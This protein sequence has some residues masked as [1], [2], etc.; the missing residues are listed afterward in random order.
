MITAATVHA[1]ARGLA[2]EDSLERERLD[3]LVQSRRRIERGTGGAIHDEF[4]G[5]EQ[6]A[7]PDVADMPVITKT[8][9]QPPLELSAKTLDPVEQLLVIDHP[10]YLER[11]GAGQRMGQIGMAVLERARTV[12]DDI[13]DARAR[14]HGADRLVATAQS[15]GDRLD[16][17]R[18][19]FLLPGVARAGA[20]HAAHHLVEEDERAVP[21]A[22][23]ADGT[24]ISLRGRHAAGGRAHNRLGD[25]RRHVFRA[26]ALEFR[27]QFSRKTGDEIG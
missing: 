2:A 12:T 17:G 5:L 10:L 25:E 6:A 18:D 24:E 19:A 13:D 21:I 27:L 1:A 23:L 22:D 7:T 9:G 26:K 3:P 11:R 16:V 4:D 8:L 15:L 20:A 14:K